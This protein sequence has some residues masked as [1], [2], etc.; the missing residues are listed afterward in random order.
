[1]QLLRIFTHNGCIGL[2]KLRI[3]ISYGQVKKT[4]VKLKNK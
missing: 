4:D 1:M 2:I 3:Y